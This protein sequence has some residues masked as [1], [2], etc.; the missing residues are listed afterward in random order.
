MADLVICMP[1]YNEAEGIFEF[2]TEIKEELSFMDFSFV[3]VDDN[4]QDK[5]AEQIASFKRLNCKSVDVHYLFNEK[6]LGHG[7]S[8]IRG[9]TS[10][11]GL[12][13]RYVISLDGDG[14]FLGKEI[15]HSVKVFIDGGFDVLEAQRTNRREPI[16]RKLVT[17]ATRMIVFIKTFRLPKDA[18]TPFRIYKSEVLPI[19]LQSLPKESLIPNLRISILCRKKNLK[20][21][22]FKVTSLPRRGISKIGTMWKSGKLHIPSRRFLTFCSRALREILF[23]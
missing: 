4:S 12:N 3:I 9:L 19:I 17:L 10:A 18:N 11:S 13:S 8:V 22:N 7:P 15:A 2:L 16:F 5:S 6:N 1:V 21:Q 14:Q 20:I 23:S